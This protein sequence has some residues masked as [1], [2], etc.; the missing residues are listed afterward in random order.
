MAVDFAPWIMDMMK[1]IETHVIGFTYTEKYIRKLWYKRAVQQNRSVPGTTEQ[2]SASAEPQDTT[3]VDWCEAVQYKTSVRHTDLC[4][5]ERNP[6]RFHAPRTR[7]PSS[8]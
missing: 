6:V 3:L 7:G 1:R 4:T 2:I 5:L 8:W